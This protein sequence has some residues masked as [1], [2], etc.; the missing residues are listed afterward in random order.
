MVE[1]LPSFGLSPADWA[2]HLSDQELD[3]VRRVILDDPD[4]NSRILEEIRAYQA[5]VR[6]CY[7]DLGLSRAVVFWNKKV[8][9]ADPPPLAINR[10]L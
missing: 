6:K 9:F 10:N 4:V 2:R 7:V 3:E 1:L 5:L 8:L